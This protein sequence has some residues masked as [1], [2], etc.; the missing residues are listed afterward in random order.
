MKTFLPAALFTLALAFGTA[1]PAA[2]EGNGEPFG[3]PQ[4]ETQPQARVV[5]DDTGSAGYPNFN[6]VAASAVGA[7]FAAT[8]TGSV[9]YPS[10]DGGAVP[11]DRTQGIAANAMSLTP[12]RS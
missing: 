7:R 10:F 5:A 8:D 4:I 2:A 9:R 11:F 12:S 1:H 6:G 3:F